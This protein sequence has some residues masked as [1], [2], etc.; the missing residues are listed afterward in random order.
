[1]HH[2][3]KLFAGI[4]ALTLIS[5]GQVSSSFELANNDREREEKNLLIE[6][7]YFDLA[8]QSITPVYLQ[9]LSQLDSL[10]ATILPHEAKD[11][12]KEI[13]EVRDMID[14]FAYAY[15]SM[16]PDFLTIFREALDEGYEAIGD[17]KDLYDAMGGKPDLDESEAA[18]PKA[19]D[20]NMKKV[21]KLRTEV[22]EWRENF[23][24]RFPQD[25]VVNFF[26]SPLSSYDNRDKDDLSK[27][28]WGG[29]KSEPNGKNTGYENLGRLLRS[30][31]K[32]AVADFDQLVALDELTDHKKAIAFHDYRKRIRVVLKVLGY[33]PAIAKN[34]ADI[35]FQQQMDQL[36]EVVKR[37]G[38][39]GD[40]LVR[41]EKK[42]KDDNYDFTKL[43]ALKEKVGVKWDELNQDL[44]SSNFVDT[45]AAIRKSLRK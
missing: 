1:M 13:V 32:I 33:F 6:P 38:K 36:A 16:E 43:I 14:L 22:F 28:Y 17:F 37:F 23:Y 12:R 2:L 41:Y 8:K 35:V 9:A 5:C 15:P 20:Y 45:I 44:L 25:F 11:I 3:T 31:L 21:K 39:I 10:H 30:Q 26:N 29:V 42:K 18:D 27:F 40:K 4:T 7:S 24:T 34:P 19:F